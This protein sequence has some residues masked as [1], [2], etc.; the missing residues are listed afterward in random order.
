LEAAIEE[1]R[2]ALAE[3]A[4]APARLPARRDAI[5]DAPTEM[6]ANHVVISLRGHLQPTAKTLAVLGQIEAAVSLLRELAESPDDIEVHLDFPG[7]IRL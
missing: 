7:G 3:P 5:D 1:E 2:A 6:P 4:P